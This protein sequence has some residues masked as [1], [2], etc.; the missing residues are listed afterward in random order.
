VV[1]KKTNK[2]FDTE[3]YYGNSYPLYFFRTE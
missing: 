2:G 1:T 3:R